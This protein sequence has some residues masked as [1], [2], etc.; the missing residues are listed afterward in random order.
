MRLTTAEIDRYGPIANRRP[1][2]GEGVTVCYGPNE[3]GKTLHLEALLRLLEPD[4]ATVLDGI[5]RVEG[6]PVGRVVV[7]HADEHHELGN[8]TALSD[9]SRVDADALHNVFVVRNS[10]LEL[11]GGHDYYASLTDRLGDVHT[12]ELATIQEELK[13][14]GRL[15]PTERLA[16]NPES[17]YAKDVRD[18]ADALAAEIRSYVDEA[19]DEGLDALE[20]R[21]L[22]VARELQTA[23]E[24]VVEGDAAA[25]VAEYER[26]AERLEAYQTASERLEAL[27][28]FE[29]ETLAALRERRRDAAGEERR[30]EEL[31]DAV[32]ETRED[33]ERTEANLETAVAEL[34]ALQRREGAVE[35]VEETLAAH[36][37]REDGATGAERRAESSRWLAPAALVGGGV[38]AAVG[39]VATSTAALGIGAVLLVVGI[40]AA[41]SYR[42]ATSRIA[43]AEQARTAVVR[44]ARDAGFDVDDV[45][46]VPAAID[47]FAARLD[48]T[49]EQRTRL[50]TER[51][52]LR[53]RLSDDRSELADRKAALREHEEAIEETLAAAGVEDVA[54][55]ARQVEARESVRNE[56]QTAREILVDR[57]GE[58]DAD[59]LAHDEPGEIAADW[60]RRLEALVVDVDRTAVD[61]TKYDEAA[62]AAARE[63]VAELEA[64]QESLAARLADHHDRIDAF[65][66]RARDLDTRPFVDEQVGLEARSTDGLAELATALEGVVAAIER[67]AELSRKA[68]S[69]FAEIES[70]EEAK[71][72]DLFDPDGPA[73]ATFRRLTGGRYTAVTY[74]P[75]D[76]ALSVTR[77]DGQT[78]APDRLSNGTAD[79][80]YFATRVSLA[81]QLLDREPGFFLLDDAFL[82]ADPDR[83]YSGFEVLCELADEGWQVLYFTA[84]REVGEEMVA[85]FGLECV[86][87][88][89]LIDGQGGTEVGNGAQ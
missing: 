79:Q 57:F 85:E 11:T 8:G 9:V 81:Q 17:D 60:E 38:A 77:R 72:T 45:G 13:A 53:E 73:S 78:F 26:L 54:T 44:A 12:T 76:R 51:E 42:R 71:I 3:S 63:R 84:K 6:A 62:L 67:D 49:T 19:T 59:E 64:E 20:V 82:T 47:A 88:E 39:A 83:L 41:V 5:D 24:A 33:I 18:D 14:S 55:F 74:D 31:E 7:E 35:N 46:A 4:V 70:D 30:I 36:R 50:E 65:A 16:S 28:S 61:P 32:V 56:Q 25:R 87:F 22:A 34:S 37:E 15:T 68:L 40:A 21:R 2:C 66:D 48:A 43:A 27:S 89:G 10:D 86:E 75:E 52:G 1:A 69:V 29:R 23:S 58:P 80:L